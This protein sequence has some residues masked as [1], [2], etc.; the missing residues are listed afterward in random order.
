MGALVRL[1]GSFAI[2]VGVL[3]PLV[4]LVVTS[5]SDR[6]FFPDLA[7]E[8]GW[9]AWKAML[10]PSS[11]VGTGLTYSVA[12]AGAATLISLVIGIPAG[13]A[14]GLYRFPG[15]QAVEFLLLAPALV[16]GLA[17]AMGIH[18]LFIHYGLADTMPGVVLVHLIP[19]LPY[20]TMIF[21]GIFANY[22]VGYED[23]AR[24]LGAGPFRIFWLVTFP[25]IFPAIAVGGLF[26]FLISWSQYVLT[27][28]IGGGRVITLPMLVFSFARSGEY[29]ITAA[30][31]LIFVAPTVLILI[32]TSR[33]VSG[34]NPL[35][36]IGRV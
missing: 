33:F 8:F 15:R 21:T 3:G 36:G 14:L 6:W 11:N 17:V 29:A 18:V 7:P 28:L 26:A 2:V 16:P 12:I 9:M 24:V 13:R 22:E 4:P 19:I 30:V 25:A 1:A 34:E 32:A 23:Q 31:S 35:G 20:V 10:D 5:F 27:V